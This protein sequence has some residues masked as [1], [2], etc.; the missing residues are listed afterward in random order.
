[1]SIGW[2]VG[3]SDW[4]GRIPQYHSGPP[5]TAWISHNTRR[6]IPEITRIAPRNWNQ[7]DPAKRYARWMVSLGITQATPKHHQRTHT[8]PS[9]ME[10]CR[11]T[12]PKLLTIQL[13]LPTI[14][15]ILGIRLALLALRVSLLQ[16]VLRVLL[17]W[18]RNE[19]W[20]SPNDMDEF[21]HIAQTPFE[22]SEFRIEDAT[23]AR[24]KARSIQTS[25]K[26]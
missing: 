6:R 14:L 18:A 21:H 13:M 11:G 8:C 20:A 16:V 2:V 10:V 22:Q 12:N 19:W 1:M 17:R 9:D 7:P 24:S 4:Y 26:Y 5:W 25:T 23:V 15:V 3:E